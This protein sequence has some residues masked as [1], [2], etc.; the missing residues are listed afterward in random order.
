MKPTFLLI[1]SLI[2]FPLAAATAQVGPVDDSGVVDEEAAEQVEEFTANLSI[3][4]DFGGDPIDM[5]LSDAVA[6]G[7]ENNLQLQV[8]RF[9]PLISYENQE[10]SWGSFDPNFFM[11]GGYTSAKDPNTNVLTGSGDLRN[12]T[13][14]TDGRTGVDTLVPWLGAS[15]SLEFNSEKTDTSNF[16]SFTAIKPV[17]ESGATVTG[18]I[19]LLRGLIWN[20]PWTRVKTSQSL[21]S[22]SR[23]NFKRDL[24]DVVQFIETAYWSVVAQKQSVRVAEKSLETALSL[25]D[26]TKTQY[27]VG[28][29]SRVEVVE[30]EAGV[31]SR[32]FDLI[33]ALN[34]YRRAQDDL[35]DSVLGTQLTPGSRLEI[36]PADDPENYVTYQIDITEATGKAFRN[37]PELK[38]AA[39]EIERQEFELKFAKNQRLPQLDIQG[40]YGIRGIRGDDT[41]LIPGA[42]NPYDGSYSDT[43]DDWFSSQ[44]GR[45]FVVRG[46]V[47]IPIGNVGARH[48]VSRQQLELRKLNT[49]LVQLRQ[50]IILEVRDSTRNLESAQE[51]I[52]AANRRKIAAAEQLRAERVRL[53]YGESTPFR[54][55]EREEDLVEAEN[56]W[57]LALFTYRRSVVDLHRAQGTILTQRNIVVDQA[58]TL[59]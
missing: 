30:A 19:P 43:F 22:G 25:L 56:E 53:E 58:A 17:Y 13:Y 50:S 35:I 39:Y 48:T 32:E 7:I 57:I 28:V 6:R 12:K 3:N 16:G 14:R 45:E 5:R 55:L 47:S 11:D 18:T 10:G 29:K 49:R 9:D 24:M 44:G 37:R 46:V 40:S 33:R 26:Q 36:I 21:Y 20:E 2:A 4:R 51:G 42:N 54:V 27:E 52:E 23:Q 8:E 59:R 41:G 1:V 38:E 34:L 15:V 31:A